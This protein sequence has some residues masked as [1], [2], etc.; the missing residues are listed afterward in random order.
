MNYRTFGL[1]NIDT[2]PFSHGAKNSVRLR[3]NSVKKFRELMYTGE[4]S[5][6]RRASV[7]YALSEETDRHGDD[8]ANWWRWDATNRQVQLVELPL[9]SH[10]GTVKS[11]P[12]AT[13]APHACDKTSFKVNYFRFTVNI[14][15]QKD[16]STVH[17]VFYLRA[18]HKTH[19][20]LLQ[21]NE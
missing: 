11:P 17:H 14:V 2:E 10:W 7:G 16:R 21:F 8:V 20:I 6:W 13:K 3:Q 12:P 18:P 15:A 5:G 1:S 9:P 19:V 4:V